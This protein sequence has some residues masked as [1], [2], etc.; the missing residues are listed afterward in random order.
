VAL[1]RTVD[2]EEFRAFLQDIASG[3]FSDV[4]WETLLEEHLPDDDVGAV[5]RDE[6]PR[7][8]I[9][10]QAQVIRFLAVR[11]HAEVR[12][13]A[14]EFLKADREPVIQLTLAEALAWLGEE[15]GFQEIERIGIEAMETEKRSGPSPIPFMWIHEALAPI[16]N[17][18]AQDLLTKLLAIRDSVS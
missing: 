4:S 7:L 2:Q 17:S 15:L 18:K 9:Y 13:F 12:I 3:V 16:P 8:N 5:L 11:G 10:A 6:L 14:L 1:S